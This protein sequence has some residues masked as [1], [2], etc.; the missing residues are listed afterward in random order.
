MRAHG[1]VIARISRARRRGDALDGGA[2]GAGWRQGAVGEHR[3][4]PGVVPGKRS[5]GGAHASGGS[6]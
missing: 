5:G 6:T 4:G 1:T 3:W 2:V